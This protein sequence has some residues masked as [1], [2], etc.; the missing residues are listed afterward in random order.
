MQNIPIN[1]SFHIPKDALKQCIQIGSQRHTNNR[2]SRVREQKYTKRKSGIDLSVQGVIGEYSILK[3][4]GLPITPLFNTQPNSKK[5]DRGDM[6]YKKSK[7]DIKCPEGHHCP[8]Q[9]RARDRAY[10]SD[11]YALCTLERPPNRRLFKDENDCTYDADENIE[12]IFRGC[13]RASDLFRQENFI[14][15]W[16]DEFYVF[17]QE[18]LITLEEASI[19]ASI[20]SPSPPSPPSPSFPKPIK[21]LDCNPLQT[22]NPTEPNLAEDLI[23]CMNATK[24]RQSYQI[25]STPLEYPNLAEDLIIPQNNKRCHYK[26]SDQ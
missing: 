26:V 19:P 17:P 3:L 6:I 5:N 18:R 15:K 4:F 2:K 16:G 25:S 23:P 12:V 11:I 13:V 20:T 10:P 8:L 1:T 24:K 14:K 9:T 21:V 22:Q 7:V